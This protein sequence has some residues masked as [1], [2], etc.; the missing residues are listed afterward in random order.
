M[1]A[2]MAETDWTAVPCRACSLS[3]SW[4]TS[5]LQPCCWSAQMA[6]RRSCLR[7]GHNR[8]GL[9]LGCQS[10]AWQGRAWVPARLKLTRHGSPV[11]FSGKFCFQG[12]LVAKITRIHDIYTPKIV[13][14]FAVPC[15]VLARLAPRTSAGTGRWPGPGPPRAL[16]QGDP[17]GPYFFELEHS[18]RPCAC[19]PQVMSHDS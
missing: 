4:P 14:Y 3:H 11:C 1:L 16:Q 5:R 19:K 8:A 6:S 15:R 2:A 13:R 7:V 10:A 18:L 9:I 12:V 17:L